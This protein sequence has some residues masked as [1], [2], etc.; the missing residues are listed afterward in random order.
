MPVP[1]LYYGAVVTNTYGLPEPG[2][3]LFTPEGLYPITGTKSLPLNTSV[4]QGIEILARTLDQVDTDSPGTAVTVFGYSQSAIIGSLLQEGYKD[5]TIAQ[6]QDVEF[7]FVG[8]EMNP[9]GGF[10]SRFPRLQLPSL[11][12]DFYGP[13]PENAYPTTNYALEYDGF[14]D[15]PRYPINFL[16]VLNAALGIVFVH[17]QYANPEF[18][19][20]QDVLDAVVLP[21]TDPDQKYFFLPTE[22]LPLLEPLRAVPLIGN[23]LADLVQ[24]VLKAIVDLGYADAAHGYPSGG[25]PIANV[26]TPFGLFP[27]VD[28]LEVLN[29]VVNG[30]GEGVRDFIADFGPGGSIE[31]E[32]SAIALPPVSLALPTADGIISALQDAI[33][34]AVNWVSNAAASIYAALL[35]TADIVNAILTSLPAYNIDLFLEGVKQ[36][37]AGDI[38]GGVVNAIGLPIAADV[39]LITTASL[40]GVLVWA[41]GI[42]GAFGVDVGT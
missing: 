31:R 26:L 35:P 4:D 9:N 14:A 1:S 38:I 24:P 42:A 11:G 20:R 32:L 28:P 6:D 7:V 19:T 30:I 13:T 33:T 41:Q 29:R 23:P 39:G 22:N 36:V 37:L 18:V 8:N 40:V 3:I 25:Q 17:T 12:L 27:Q 10:L 21:T 2:Q 5:F 34:G 15:F 16:S